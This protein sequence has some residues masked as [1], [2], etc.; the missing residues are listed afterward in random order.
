MQRAVAAKLAGSEESALSNTERVAQLPLL[1][2]AMEDGY[3]AVRRFAQQSARVSAEKLALLKLAAAL[4]D[5]DFIGTASARTAALQ[6]IRNVTPQAAVSDT[7]GGLLN[8]DGSAN[9]VLLNTLRA[10]ADTTAINI[11]E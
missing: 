4:Q 11:G 3:P 6:A 2:A 10:E 5:F 7:L 8:V 9:T 1:L